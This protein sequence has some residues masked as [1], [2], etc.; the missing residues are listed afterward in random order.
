MQNLTSNNP[1][2]FRDPDV[3]GKWPPK[4]HPKAQATKSVRPRKK[5]I[6]ALRM[7]S[8]FT[9][10]IPGSCFTRGTSRV[11]QRKIYS[12]L[13]QKGCYAYFLL[14]ATPGGSR[15]NQPNSKPRFHGH[16]PAIKWRVR[17]RTP[18]LLCVFLPWYLAHS[19]ISRLQE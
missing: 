5:P 10:F 6:F 14:N 7:P 12:G 15:E 4:C 3:K 18:I 1:V 16:M 13:S 11:R 9:P 8:S 19:S 17:H 2:K